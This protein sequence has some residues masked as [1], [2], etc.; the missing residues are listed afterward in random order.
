M[1]ARLKVC[2]LGRRF[3]AAS[4]L[5]I[6]KSR[7]MTWVSESLEDSMCTEIEGLPKDPDL[8]TDF[9]IPRATKGA[10]R[11]LPTTAIVTPPETLPIVVVLGLV[12][13]FLLVSFKI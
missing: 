8:F 13:V 7:T 1:Q 10:I 6:G 3:Q 12:V 9:K 5:Y 4:W 11:L 2:G